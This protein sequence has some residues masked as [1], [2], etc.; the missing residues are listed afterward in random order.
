MAGRCRER[1]FALITVMLLLALVATFIAAY[2]TLT[3]FEQSSTRS[4]MDGVRGMYAAEAGLNVRAEMV[5]QVFEGYNRPAG[6]SPETD[7][8]EPP[9]SARNVGA[10][11]FSCVDYE[12]SDRRAQTYVVEA[13]GNPVAIVIPRGELFQNLHAQEYRYFVTRRPPERRT[14]PR[15]CSRCTS[16]AAS[17]R[18]SSSRR[19]TTRTSRSCPDR[20][21]TLERPRAHQRR[22]VPRSRTRR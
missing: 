5:R 1:G 18:C 13:P 15:R 6:D 8:L 7:A 10:G 20:R 12:F 9:C 21:W 14:G 11:D 2:F 19:S 3:R 16:R 22:S 4:V 17:C